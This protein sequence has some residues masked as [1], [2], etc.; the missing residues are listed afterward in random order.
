MLF[1]KKNPLN[2]IIRYFSLL[3]LGGVIR[4]STLKYL[5]ELLQQH[6]PDFKVQQPYP[7]LLDEEQLSYFSHFYGESEHLKMKQKLI[8]LYLITFNSK[9][10]GAMVND[11]KDARK[12][13]NV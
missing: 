12:I 9:R 7:S 5:P 10:Y 13:L 8:D 3:L 1:S 6:Q 2:K 11:K 4:G